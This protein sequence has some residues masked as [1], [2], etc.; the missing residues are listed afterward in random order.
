MLRSSCGLNIR[1]IR[2]STL[3]SRFNTLRF[4]SNKPTKHENIWT[5]PNA[6]TASR[7]VS[8]LPLGYSICMHDYKTA[9][10]ILVYA[11][12]SDALDGFLA[13]RYNMGSVLGSILDPAADKALM[14][15]KAKATLTCT[16]TYAGMIPL[17]LAVII[18]GRDV[19]LSL[20]AFY[21]RYASLS[22]PKTFKRYWDFSI[23][24]AEVKPTNIS[25]VEDEYGE[26]KRWLT[27]ITLIL[28]G[29]TTVSPL[30]GFDTAILLQSL[31]WTV[32]GTTIASA[33][34]YIRNKNAVRY[35]N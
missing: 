17:P 25:K 8:C 28:M 16:L 12:V 32:G 1:N 15:G 3:L 18:L 30:I 4:Q 14:S 13:R 26:C 2:R 27:T 7:I 24:S 29:A 6:L 21:I 19:G 31:Q 10:A 20:S 22:E 5:I 9:T 33:L 35:L 23:P 11:G 34:S